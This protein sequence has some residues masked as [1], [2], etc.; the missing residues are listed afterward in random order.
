MAPQGGGEDLNAMPPADAVAAVIDSRDMIDLEGLRAAYAAVGAGQAV[1]KITGSAERTVPTTTVSL[2]VIFALHSSVPMAVLAEEL[3]RLNAQTPA[4]EWPDII[5]VA[6]TGTINYAGQFPGDGEMS[7]FLPPAEGALANYTPP[8]YI[9]MTMKA[10]ASR[11]FSQMAVLLSC[12]SCD[13]HAGRESSRTSATLW[14]LF[15][16]TPSSSAAIRYNLEGEIKPV[17]R[18]FLSG[19]LFSTPAYAYRG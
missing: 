11:A 14:K 17:P 12:A 16:K 19:P 1:G 10:L 15:P 7:L 3:Q 2:G 13:L 4:R 18:Q 9:V 6:D 8:M 5:V